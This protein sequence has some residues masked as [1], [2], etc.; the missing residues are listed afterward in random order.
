VYYITNMKKTAFLLFRLAF[1]SAVGLV[2]TAAQNQ[3]VPPD[4]PFQTVHLINV[5]S[6]DAEKTLLAA[7]T[8]INAAIAKAGCAKCAYHLWKVSGT[9]AGGYNCLWIS[10]WPDREVYVKVHNSAEYQAA[11]NRH[12]DIGLIMKTQTYNR[13]VEVT[14]GK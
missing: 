5:N 8:D 10:S 9:Q 11:L 3:D 14:S 1:C 2:C 12:Q 13:Y 6:A 4:Q 7:L